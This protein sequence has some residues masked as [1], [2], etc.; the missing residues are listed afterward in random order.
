MERSEF[1]AHILKAYES[2]D[3]I[4]TCAWCQRLY[5]EG[6]WVFA[7]R[8]ALATID[9]PMTL[10]HSICPTCTADTPASRSQLPH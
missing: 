3:L 8:G 10:S 7:P 1:V 5:I 6:N 9:P 2:G 4:P